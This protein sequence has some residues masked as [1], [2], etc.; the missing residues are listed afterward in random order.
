[1]SDHS[2]IDVLM[3]SI[4]KEA[5]H[6]GLHMKDVMIMSDADTSDPQ[7]AELVNDKS[8]KE[9]LDDPN[10]DVGYAIMTYFLIGD[11]AFSERVQNPE[12]FDTDQQFKM[13]VPTD[14]ELLKDKLV[15]KFSSLR[16][17]IDSEDDIFDALFADDDD[18]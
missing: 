5:A 18:D 17:N 11:M 1:M 4:K 16:D 10:A 3:E 14:A 12:K 8:M 2:E 9:I 13:L 7:I 15:D 6:I